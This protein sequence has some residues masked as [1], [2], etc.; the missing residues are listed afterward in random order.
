MPQTPLSS[1]PVTELTRRID[2]AIDAGDTHSICAAVKTALEYLTRHELGCIDERLLR[3][4]AEDYTRRLLYRDPQGRYTIVLMIWGQG[5][6]T[7]VHDH[8]GFWCVESVYRG[9][10]RVLS[11]DL[12]EE[13]PGDQVRFEPAR[14][15]FAGVGEAGAL[16][17]PFDYHVLENPFDE[18]AV[19]VH[20]YGGEMDRCLVFEPVVGAPGCYERQVRALSYSPLT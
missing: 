18:V 11:Y 17:P 3:P 16:I 20:V 7:K 1:S 6:G 4:R 12:V 10:I 9:R 14:E 8:A 5:Q 13:L 2:Q 15:V 19:T